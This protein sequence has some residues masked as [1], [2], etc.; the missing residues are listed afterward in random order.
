MWRDVW[1]GAIGTPRLLGN[2]G[3]RVCCE[4]LACSWVCLLSLIFCLLKWIACFLCVH[5][6]SWCHCWHLL[7]LCRHIRREKTCRLVFPA[8]FRV[9]L[10]QVL[11]QIP[12]LIS[13]LLQILNKVC[14]LNFLS[15]VQFQVNVFK[16]I[17]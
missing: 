14:K 8:E 4:L 13:F 17:N 15:R 2:V 7:I 12:I 16:L 1:V 3:L 10:Q 9:V 6:D 11:R 5:I